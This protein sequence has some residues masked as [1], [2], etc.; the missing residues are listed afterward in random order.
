MPLRIGLRY[1][2][3]GRLLPSALEGTCYPFFFS[4]KVFL[5]AIKKDSKFLV[6]VRG[7]TEMA[8]AIHLQFRFFTVLSLSLSLSLSG[9]STV[10]AHRSASRRLS[11][12]TICMVGKQGPDDQYLH[13]AVHNLY[14]WSHTEPTLRLAESSQNSLPKRSRNVDV[15]LVSR[16]RIEGRQNLALERRKKNSNVGCGF[17]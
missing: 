1:L 12:K 9:R 11:D 13:Y 6:R 7:E 3:N 17:Q 2:S 16:S 8:D 5:D 14:G 4:S 15:F 10:A